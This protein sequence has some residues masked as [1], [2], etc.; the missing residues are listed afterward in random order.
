MPLGTKN[1]STKLLAGPATVLALGA[2]VTFGPQILYPNASA[3]SAQTEGGEG[4]GQGQGGQGQGGQGQGGHG[5]GG[6]GAGQGGPGEDSDGQGPRA[7]SGGNEGGKPVWASKGIPEVELGRLNVARSPNKVL[8]KALV[9]AIATVTPDIAAFY[10][11]SLDDAIAKLSLEWDTV[12]LYGSLPQSLAL[13]KDVLAD[14]SISVPG[15]SNDPDTLMAMLL[16]VAS[17]KTVLISTNTVLAITTIL[18]YP[19]TVP[20]A[21]AL[22]TDAEAVRISVLAGHG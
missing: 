7:G 1:T 20:E 14:G 6:E 3:A 8:D 5:Q 18:G 10:N 11:L 16:G 19:M 22:A 17:D 4:G 15:I 9:E 13:L 2:A 21:S 12:T